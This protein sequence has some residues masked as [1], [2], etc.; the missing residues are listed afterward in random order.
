MSKEKGKGKAKPRKQLTA[1]TVQLIDE[2]RFLEGLNDE[3]IEL[4]REL[5]SHCNKYGVEAKNAK[6]KLDISIVLV[7]N[8]DDEL[9]FLVTGQSKKVPPAVPAV[10][11]TTIQDGRVLGVRPSGST[12]D[13]PEQQVFCGKDGRPVDQKTRKLK[14]PIL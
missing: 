4:M 13:S 1:L 8:P 10:T 14:R 11:T 5:S 3:L 2:G 9:A 6:A 7:A 12:S